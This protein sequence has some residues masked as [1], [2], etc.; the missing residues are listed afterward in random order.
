MEKKIIVLRILL[1][2]GV[3]ITLFFINITYS[4]YQENFNTSYNLGIKKWIIKIN[5]S[6]I[7]NLGTI[8]EVVIPNLVENAHMANE[9]FVPGREAYVELE[10]D[11]SEV[12]VDFICDINMEQLNSTGLELDD[13]KVYGYTINDG[14]MQDVPWQSDIEDQEITLN[15]DHTET[16]P[17]S[18]G[19][20]HKK[21]IKIYFR[22]ED[23]DTSSSGTDSTNQVMNNVDDTSYVGENVVGE[24][25]S[26]LKYKLNVSFKQNIS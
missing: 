23:F 21:T 14:T 10:L 13:F 19:T 24:T 12:D 22:W 25:K 26:Q 9:V 8:S 6:D 5:N 15:I 16:R 20:E 2:L 4:K 17:I 18:G 1:I 3:C 7:Y 11:Y